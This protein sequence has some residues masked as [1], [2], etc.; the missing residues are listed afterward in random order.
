MGALKWGREMATEVP[1]I[2]ERNLPA[3]TTV[4]KHYCIVPVTVNK[5]VNGGKW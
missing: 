2:E 3:I 1:R 5:Y 4:C